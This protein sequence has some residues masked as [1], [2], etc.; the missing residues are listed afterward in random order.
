MIAMNKPKKPALPTRPHKP[1]GEPQK[2]IFVTEHIRGDLNLIDNKMSMAELMRKI[3]KVVGDRDP[4]KVWLHIEPETGYYGETNVIQHITEIKEID[5]PNYIK[6]LEAFHKATANYNAKMAKHEA[7]LKQYHIDVE[8]YDY[9]MKAYYDWL[10][11][12]KKDKGK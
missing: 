10:V 1:A 8:Q 3:S 5:N 12:Q 4:E 2:Q 6:Q 11:A 9:D 7:L